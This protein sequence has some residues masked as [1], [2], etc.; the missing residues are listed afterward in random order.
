MTKVIDLILGIES[1]EQQCV[2]IK[3][4]L[5]SE[6]LKQYMVTIGVYQSLSNSLMYEHIC[7]KNI[8]ELH[9][10]SEKCDDQKH[11]KA[12]LEE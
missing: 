10:S 6:Q 9:K 5:R 4:L 12:I 11:Y 8:M 2:V 3:G 7:L 1:F